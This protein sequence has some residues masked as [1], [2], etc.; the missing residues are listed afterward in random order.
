MAKVLVIKGYTSERIKAEIEKNEKY[1]TG[2]KLHAIYNISKGISSRKL[3][4]FYGFSFSQILNW[5]HRFEAEGVEGLNDKHGRGRKSKLTDSQLIL[6]KELLMSKTPLDFG[7]NTST[8][9]G[10]LV[11]KLIKDCFGVIYGQANVYN[12][13]NKIGF[14]YQKAK[15]KY[16]EADPE[17]QEI[18][19]EDF[20]KKSTSL[21]LTQCC[22]TK[23]NFRCQTRLH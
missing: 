18:F 19:K 15:G 4:D 11:G 22:C 16:P 13:L 21:P 9:T 20:K 12:L 17:K 23:T 2:V 5:A 3:V 1:K 14:S 10:V 6:L 7:H 8:W